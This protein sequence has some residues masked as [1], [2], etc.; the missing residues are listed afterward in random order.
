MVFSLVL[1]CMTCC[2]AGK[3]AQPGGMF[4]Y[5]YFFSSV[6]PYHLNINTLGFSSYHIIDNFCVPDI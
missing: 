2:F 1:T 5:P 4:H 6:F 3:N